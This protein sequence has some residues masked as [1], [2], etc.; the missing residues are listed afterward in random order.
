MKENIA[1]LMTVYNGSKYFEEQI[2]SVLRQ[3]NINVKLFI[4]VDLSDDNSYEIIRDKYAHLENICLLSYGNRYGSAGKNFY[5]TILDSDFSGCDYIAFADQDDIWHNNKLSYSVKVIKEK[6]VDAYSANVLAFYENGNTE[7]I[8]KA[9]QQVEY[10]YLFEAA[11]PGCTYV[12]TNTLAMQF[13]N[14]LYENE[15]ARSVSL[16]DWLLY[17][18]ARSR[19]FKWLIDDRVNMDYRQHQA[20]V[21]GANNSWRSAMKRIQMVKSG[22]YKK[23]VLK[24]SES[25]SVESNP[26]VQRLKIGNLKSRLWLIMHINKLRRRGRDRFALAFFIILNLV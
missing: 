2:N 24:I 12:I 25:I 14:F 17:A 8:D 21:V 15:E 16:H 13:K 5:R 6:K 4:S 7:I 20:N 18:F 11:G 1:V 9:Q 23:E 22:W 10:D 26:V 19:K 3:E